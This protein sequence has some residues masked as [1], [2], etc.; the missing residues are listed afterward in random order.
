MGKKWVGQSFQIPSIVKSL[1]RDSSSSDARSRT[2]GTKDAY[3]LHL[4][5]STRGLIF[6][7]D[8]QKLKYESLNVRTGSEQ[9]FLH[10]ESLQTL[11]L[12]DDMRT[13]LGN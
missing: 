10:A 5:P 13:L 6:V 4:P 3:P 8:D 7:N 1:S 2:R 9:K 11:G 12:Y